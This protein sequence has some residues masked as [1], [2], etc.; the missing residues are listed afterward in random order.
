MEIQS[1]HVI[2]Q[3][4]SPAARWYTVEWRSS[5]SDTR[6]T[7]LSS[8]WE[9]RL[10]F[11]CRRGAMTAAPVLS[12]FAG[13]GV[14]LFKLRWRTMN[15]LTTTSAQTQE[16]HAQTPPYQLW[17]RGQGER[18]RLICWVQTRFSSPIFCPPLLLNLCFKDLPLSKHTSPSHCALAFHVLGFC[19]CLCSKQM[20]SRRTVPISNTDPLWSIA[21]PRTRCSGSPQPWVLPVWLMTCHPWYLIALYLMSCLHAS[22]SPLPQ[23]NS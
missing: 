5:C 10:Y 8:P 19:Q 11:L 22:F 1:G 14:V 7:S 4:G 6:L 15:T 2:S 16:S 23:V 12:T 3:D 13:K 18:Q 21:Q 17:K 9:P 20:P